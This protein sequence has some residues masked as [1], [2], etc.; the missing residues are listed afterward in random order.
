[1]QAAVPL[2]NALQDKLGRT[3]VPN[4]HLWIRTRGFE[5]FPNAVL[6][7]ERPP[8]ERRFMQGEELAGFAVAVRVAEQREPQIVE[9][10]ALGKGSGRA[11]SSSLI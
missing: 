2:F 5:E 11:G 6:A 1:L 10:H 8:P 7:S 4:F 9:D 3:R